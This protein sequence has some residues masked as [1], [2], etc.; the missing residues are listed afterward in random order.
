MRDIHAVAFDAYGTLFDVR[1]VQAAVEDAFPGHGAAVTELWRIK[2]LEYTWLRSLMDRYADFWTVTDDALAF[3]LRSVGVT[4][5]DEARRGLMQA[6]LQL[7]SYPEVAEALEALAPRPLHI[8]S[9]GSPRMLEAMVA[10]AGIDRLLDGLI[11]VDQARIYKP[12]PRCYALVTD[13]LGLAPEQVLF[14][15][16]NPWDAAG[17]KSFGFTT[18][19]VRRGRAIAEELPARPDVEVPDLLRLAG[20]L[21]EG[22]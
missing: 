11:S 22:S 6:Y 4:A 14:V 5:D 20:W 13:T 3:A 10:H 7:E 19:W 1:S 2:Q 9:N 17:G 18:A 8:F 12:S 16:A 21:D 15:S